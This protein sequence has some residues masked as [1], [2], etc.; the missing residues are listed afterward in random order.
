MTSLLGSNT[1]SFAT[2]CWVGAKLGAAP[3]LTLLL[4][5][6]PL[7]LDLALLYLSQ[8]SSPKTQT[9]KPLWCYE[10]HR[11]TWLQQGISITS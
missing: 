2:S 11:V 1:V 5:S 3:P 4:L 9:S 8:G 10:S 7:M 6:T